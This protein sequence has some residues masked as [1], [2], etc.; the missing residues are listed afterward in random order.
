MPKDAAE[1][2]DHMGYWLRQVSNQVSGSFAQKIENLDV[3]VPEWAFM[4]LLYPAAR[5]PPSQIATELSLTRGGV[6]K[7]ADRMIAKGNIAREDN[8][9]DGRAQML[10]LTSKGAALVPKLAALAD[11]NELEFFSHL[12]AREKEQLMALLKKTVTTLGTTAVPLS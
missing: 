4:R 1:L 7:L 6:T 5:K 8:P 12:S 9:E 10:K 3:S 11:K 2:Y